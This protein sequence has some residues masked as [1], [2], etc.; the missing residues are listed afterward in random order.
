MEEEVNTPTTE[1]T[2]TEAEVVD[3]FAGLIPED[4]QRFSSSYITDD[5]IITIVHDITL[6]DI[7]I[8]TLLCV[9]LIAVVLGRVIGGVRR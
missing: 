4:P 6:G 3:P 7:L 1:A 5:Y 8:A 2:E 9:L